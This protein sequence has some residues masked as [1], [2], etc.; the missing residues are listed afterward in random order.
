[1]EGAKKVAVH[2]FE[3]KKK[4]PQTIVISTFD[5]ESDRFQSHWTE[6]LKT[7]KTV[8]KQGVGSL[9]RTKQT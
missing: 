2:T 6:I 7:T 5:S 1:M 3:K 9:L 4:S 8:M